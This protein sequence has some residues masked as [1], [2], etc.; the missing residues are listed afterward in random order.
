MNKT[1]E[2]IDKKVRYNVYLPQKMV[3]QLQK[4]SE[5]TDIPVS[6]IIRKAIESHLKKIA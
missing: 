3:V 1:E 5:K 6:R 4:V 2:D